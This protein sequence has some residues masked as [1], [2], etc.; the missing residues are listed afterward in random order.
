MTETTR[1]FDQ[2]CRAFDGDAW[3]GPALLSALDGVT[4]RQAAA[5]PWPGTHSIHEI[6]RH[7]TTWTL[8]VARRIEHRRHAPL[9]GDEWP[10][11]P[12]ADEAAWPAALAALCQ[13][14]EEL[15]LATARL[16]DDELDRV[17]APAPG[18]PDG[19][20]DSPYVLLHGTAQHYLYHA[21]QVALLRKYA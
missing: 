4:P 20:G 1:L 5:H 11:A 13:A 2:L 15:L 6:V 7:L 19:P 18:H 17:P 21:G 8:T 14:H 3:C 9:A 10:A 16:H 12:A